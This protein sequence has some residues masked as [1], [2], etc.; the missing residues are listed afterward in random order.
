MTASRPRPTVPTVDD[1]PSSGS[2]RS[3]STH[4]SEP[5]IDVPW[6]YNEALCLIQHEASKCPTCDAFI[7]HYMTAEAQEEPSLRDA[8]EARDGAV[9]SA[10]QQSVNDLCRERDRAMLQV[11]ELHR[12]VNELE[13]SL[14]KAQ[15]AEGTH[16]PQ[17]GPSFSRKRTRNDQT[18][19]L[20]PM[21]ELTGDRVGLWIIEGPLPPIQKVSTQ[22]IWR[23][24]SYLVFT[25]QI[26]I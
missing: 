23:A 13:S 1:Q 22:D 14:R 4:P 12:R 21:E 20:K 6:Q 8:C 17:P 2:D 16:A 5:G 15:E 11:T 3:E 26:A 9:G 25:G 7:Q 18:S 10:P 24:K 19:H